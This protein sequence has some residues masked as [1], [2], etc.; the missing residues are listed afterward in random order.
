MDVPNTFI[1]TYMSPKKYIR[2]ILIT[3]L[4]DLL[5]DMLVELDNDTY[6]NN[7]VFEKWKKVI[8]FVGLREIYRIIV[9]A[10]LLYKGFCGDLEN[11]GFE[12]NPYDPYVTDRIKVCKQ[13]T[14]RFHVDDFMYSNM[15][16]KVNDMFNKGMNRN[17][18]NH[19][20]VKYNRGNVHE[21]LGM[22]F[23]FT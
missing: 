12:F 23:N 8:Y 9:A 11:I 13:H 15:N 6:R 2:E 7:V 4:T 16:P 20:E 18:G 1:H 19:G 10:L 14:V 17:Y 21:Y 5:V 22:T 3:K